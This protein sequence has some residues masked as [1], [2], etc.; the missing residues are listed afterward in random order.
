MLF[1]TLK[2][3]RWS[4]LSCAVLLAIWVVG[5]N[6]LADRQAK[7]IEE[8][9]AQLQARYPN[10]DTND[11][12]LKL[13]A[14]T[15]RLGLFPVAIDTRTS[16]YFKAYPPFTPSEEESREW[17]NIR[18]ELE[19]YLNE[20]LFQN[21]ETIEPPPE[22]LQRYLQNNARDLEAIQNHILS[23]EP[24]QWYQ[25]ITLWLEDDR[26]VLSSTFLGLITLQH[27]FALDMLEKERSG[28]TEAAWK[29]L[30]ASWKLNTSLES[31]YNLLSP[32]STIIAGKYQ[33]GV[34]RKL[35]RLP[36]QWQ[37]RLGERDIQKSMF[38]ALETKHLYDILRIA[39]YHSV[40]YDEGGDASEPLL[41]KVLRYLDVFSKPYFTFAA[42][43]VWQFYQQ[44]LLQ[45]EQQN[46]CFE[47]GAHEFTIARWNIPGW[48]Y[49]AILY[50][51]LSKV[52]VY[53]L[54]I[55]LTQQILKVKE[56]A[57]QRG[58]W[59]ESVSDLDSDI[60]PGAAWI[61]QVSDEG[62]MS[63]ALSHPEIF[64]K[65]RQREAARGRTISKLPLEYQTRKIS[66]FKK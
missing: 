55:E 53:M 49:T 42:M 39:N 12:A 7:E 65:Q 61:Y 60:C 30:E 35:D 63:L 31:R 9:I 40:L 47:K 10:R 38:E 29:T 19:R 11:S 34:M 54:D 58:E 51:Q 41:L 52:K 4:I 57:R 26:R 33:L 66:Q 24:P 20:Q 1:Y 56:L 32:L 36:S 62:E 22:S 21:K 18:S 28:N 2:I 43:D 17:K 50:S 37:K 46:I 27:I 15:A 59:P 45:T 64:Q 13:Q 8:A 5:G 48:I 14:L 44:S 25:N 23:H 16:A 3:L 6:W